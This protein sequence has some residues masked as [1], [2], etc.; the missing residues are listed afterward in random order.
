MKTP[1]D[2]RADGSEDEPGAESSSPILQ[3]CG[4]TVEYETEAGVAVVVDDVSLTLERGKTLGLVGESGSGKTV[5][6][7]SILGLI[8]PPAGRI[9]SGS[10]WFDGRDL[11]T[12]PRPELREVRGREI[13]VIF[14]EPRRSL[15]PSFK[16]GAQIAEVARRHLKLSRQDAW[17]RAIE[18]LDLVR[19]P[20]AGKRAHEYPHTFSGGMCQR[21]MLAMALVSNPRVLIADEPT[22]ALDVT[23]QAQVLELL[24]ELQAQR[25]L[26]V[27]FITHDL[28]VVAEMSDRVAVMYAGHVV[29]EAPVREL[30]RHP[31][32]PYT[33]GLL[34]SLP[35]TQQNARR[36][37]AI[38]G[39]VPTALNWPPGC[40]FSPRCAY[41]EDKCASTLPKLADVGGAH[42]ARCVRCEE[43]HLE[44]VT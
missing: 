1:A 7:L 11:R 8:G 3:V 18:T 32:H 25:G 27:L 15:D 12:I 36:L 2:G 33:E 21:V 43:L 31:R 5:T 20:N 30:F 39:V 14:Q 4:L 41:A 13:A 26:S 38:P 34:R 9:T 29:E 44:G 40:R 10:I 22:T 28:S 42:V 6:S 24:R 35:H 16:V 23:V 37:G 17:A 19:I